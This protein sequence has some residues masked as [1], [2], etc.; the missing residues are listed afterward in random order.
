MR[1]LA[2]SVALCACCLAFQQKAVAQKFPQPTEEQRRQQQEAQRRRQ[3]DER[4][5]IISE[6]L[7]PES[8]PE[9][10]TAS[11]VYRKPT[12]KDMLLL[13]P[14]AEDQAKYKDFLRQPKTGLARL[15]SDADCQARPQVTV[16]SEFCLKYKHVFG[17]SAFSFRAGAYT[18]GRFADIAY[19]DGSLYA[20]GKL[21]LGFMSDLGTGLSLD[22]ISAA[23]GGAKY[24]FDF[25]PPETMPEI[26][27]YAARLYNKDVQHEGFSYHKI[28]KLEAN[29]TYLLRSVAYRRKQK[30]ENGKRIYDDLSI[31]E[32]K[33]VIVAFQAV[34]LSADSVTILWKELQRKDSPKIDDA[35][36]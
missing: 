35:A 33:D 22:D 15:L 17:G 26:E 1:L 12:K 24:V 29:H 34:R 32:R 11:A 28:V 14:D 23:T 21:T 10:P 8:K 25:A 27:Q 19:K 18:L 4:F 20:L 7:R 3:A 5:K 16:T 6:G 30:W 13:A 9:N 36:K 2:V 31:D